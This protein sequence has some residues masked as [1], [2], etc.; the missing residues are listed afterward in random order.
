MDAQKDNRHAIKIAEGP[1]P[2]IKPVRSVSA[3]PT[4]RLTGLLQA[5]PPGAVLERQRGYQMRNTAARIR[6]EVG[7]MVNKYC[8]DSEE[9]S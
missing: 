2:V 9:K 6:T 3:S 4:Q 5:M 1:E 8:S 7:K